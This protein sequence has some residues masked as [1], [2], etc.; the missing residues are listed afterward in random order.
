MSQLV[1]NERSPR[2]GWAWRAAF[3]LLVVAWTAIRLPLLAVLLVMEP[4]VC[5]VLSAVAALGVLC[6]LFFEFVGKVP[7]YPFWLMIGVSAGLALLML[8]YY[9]LVRLLSGP[10][11]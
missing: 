6:A 11:K 8:P 9:L 2:S 4:I 5:G 10:S 1:T 7:H 3:G